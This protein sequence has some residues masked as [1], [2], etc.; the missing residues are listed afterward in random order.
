M[1]VPFIE[2]FVKTGKNTFD[3]YR[4]KWKK[5]HLLKWQVC[6][7][8]SKRVYGKYT[9]KQIENRMRYYHQVTQLDGVVDSLFNFNFRKLFLRILMV[10]HLKLKD[11]LGLLK[12]ERKKFKLK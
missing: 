4:K 6:E 5:Q 11:K 7:L 2:E 10:Y 12:D 3:E 1:A 8:S 9:D